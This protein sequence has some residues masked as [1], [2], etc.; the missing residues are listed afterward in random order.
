MW[1][2]AA[3]RCVAKVMGLYLGQD[4]LTFHDVMSP[5]RQIPNLCAEQSPKESDD[6]RN[7]MM[8]IY[9]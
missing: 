7:Q 2:I 1:L 8:R 4:Q 3:I 5:V 9:N 6:I